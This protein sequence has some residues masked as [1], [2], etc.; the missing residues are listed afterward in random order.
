M[1]SW[2]TTH[3]TILGVRYRGRPLMASLACDL[4]I[5][6]KRDGRKY[7]Q[8][9]LD[10]H[11]CIRRLNGEPPYSIRGDMTPVPLES[12]ETVPLT[13]WAKAEQAALQS[14]KAA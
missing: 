10:A 4:M 6:E 1:S 2:Q 5:A 7:A 3:T 12:L 11:N 8:Q 14:R 9:L 13:G